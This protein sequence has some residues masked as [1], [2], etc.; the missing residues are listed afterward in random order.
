M[1]AGIESGLPDTIED[2]TPMHTLAQDIKRKKK[3]F[4]IDPATNISASG[5]RP[6]RIAPPKNAAYGKS[7][8][9]PSITPT[10]TFIPRCS[11]LYKPRGTNNFHRPRHQERPHPCIFTLEQTLRPQTILCHE[12][13]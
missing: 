4:D 7:L 12:S 9:H 11:A 8:M 3:G 6:A 5:G 1:L 2:E 10:T 13:Q